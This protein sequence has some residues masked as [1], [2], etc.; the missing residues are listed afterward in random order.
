MGDNFESILELAVKH[1]KFGSLVGDEELMEDESSEEDEEEN[2][3]QHSSEEESLEEESGA[4]DDNAWK[5]G[6]AAAKVTIAAV[7]SIPEKWI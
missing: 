3:Q 7:A 5:L 2:Y 6:I 1:V 4:E